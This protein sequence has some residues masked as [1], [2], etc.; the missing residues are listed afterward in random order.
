MPRSYFARLD[1][2]WSASPSNAD[3]IRPASFAA[4]GKE[5]TRR[6][7]VKLAFTRSVAHR[8]TAST[9]IRHIGSQAS[10]LTATAHRET[11]GAKLPISHT[12]LCQIFGFLLVKQIR[13]APAFAHKN[14]PIAAPTT[15][16]P[17][18]RQDAVDWTAKQQCGDDRQPYAHEV[19]LETLA[20]GHQQ[21]YCSQYHRHPDI[22]V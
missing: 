22:V 1:W 12:V 21:Q 11:G 5:C 9:D 10:L 3:S 20:D 8:K 13:L 14:K 15:L 19:R 18:Q 17:R 2:T 16:S 6:R 7:H 4:P